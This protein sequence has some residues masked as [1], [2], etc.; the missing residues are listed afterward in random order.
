MNPH[1]KMENFLPP[2]ESK[3]LQSIHL[4][5]ASNWDGI[6][7]GAFAV[8]VHP[9]TVSFL[10]AIV[11]YPIYKSERLKTDRFRDQSA[12]RWLLEDAGSPLAKTSTDSKKHWSVVPMRWF[13]SL[14]INNSL[15]KKHK[16]YIYNQK[17]TGSLFDNGTMSVHDDGLGGEVKPWKVMQGDMIVHF[18]GV[19]TGDIGDSWMGPWLDRTEARLPEWDNA[20]TQDDLRPAIA[21]FWRAETERLLELEHV[22]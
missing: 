16:A 4:L 22:A 10:S 20:T 2:R 11:A 19:G 9:W 21:D 1:T 5:I 8:R 12:F 17:M 18:A 14:P 6:N 15:D 3:T 7:S 13:N